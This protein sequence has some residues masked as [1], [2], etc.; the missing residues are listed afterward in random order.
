MN[1]QNTLQ[2]LQLFRVIAAL[3]DCSFPYTYN[4]GLYY[5]CIENMAGVSTYQ[6]PFACISANATPIICDSPG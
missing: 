1:R 4:G 5:R 2:M 3:T 6:R